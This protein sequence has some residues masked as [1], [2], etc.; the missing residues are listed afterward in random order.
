MKGISSAE[1]VRTIRLYRAGMLERGNLTAMNDELRVCKDGWNFP[2][3]VR[4]GYLLRT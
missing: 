2:R 4:R 1:K 3:D